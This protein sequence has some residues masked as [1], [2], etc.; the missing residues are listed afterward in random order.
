MD[1]ME[2]KIG[3]DAKTGKY[4]SLKKLASGQST[5][6]VETAK[7]EPMSAPTTSMDPSKPKKK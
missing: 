2:N 1:L 4:I 5:A 3:R 7:R 6:T